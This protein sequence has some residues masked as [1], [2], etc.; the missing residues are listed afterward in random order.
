MRPFHPKQQWK[1]T[2]TDWV[3]NDF[4]VHFVF[5]ALYV[6]KY[7][8]FETASFTG[9]YVLFFQYLFK[10]FKYAFVFVCPTARFH[11]PVIFH[12]VGGQFPIIFFQFN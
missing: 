4:F 9:G 5:F 8:A 1:R 3:W 10:Q 7:I 6:G 11:K 12:G 2:A